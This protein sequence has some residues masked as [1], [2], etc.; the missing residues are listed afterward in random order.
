MEKMATSASFIIGDYEIK[1]RIGGEGPFSIVWR[2][3]N[4]SNRQDVVLK[5]VRLSGL[6][7]KLRECLD[8][9]LNFLAKVR[10]HPNII[11]LLDVIQVDILNLD[12]GKFMNGPWFVYN[13]FP[14]P[15]RAGW[16][17]RVPSS[18]VL[19]W[20]RLGCLCSTQREIARSSCTKIYDADR[21]FY[22]YFCTFLPQLL[23]S[24]TLSLSLFFLLISIW[25]KLGWMIIG[26]GLHH[27]L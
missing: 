15:S 2:A 26:W 12:D 14:Y 19:R 21:Y 23:C 6:T 10:R 18:G 24:K 16:W 1:S 8:C 27:Q 11:R 9:E 13:L 25:R 7:R 5:Q 3:I 4:R 22:F 20:R 17:M